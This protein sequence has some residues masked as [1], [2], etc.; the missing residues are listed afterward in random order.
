MAVD[1]QQVKKYFQLLTMDKNLQFTEVKTNNVVNAGKRY[2][3][4]AWHLSMPFETMNLTIMELMEFL[5]KIVPRSHI[6]GIVIKYD[7]ELD[8][9]Q[10]V[11]SF[12]NVHAKEYVEVQLQEK[13]L[14]S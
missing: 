13:G 5:T 14:L 10:Y 1:F 2:C 4:Y 12:S 7:A 3:P 6:I 9:I 11:A 8:S